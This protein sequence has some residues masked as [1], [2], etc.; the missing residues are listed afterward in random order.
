LRK[1]GKLQ[2]VRIGVKYEKEKIC[3]LLKKVNINPGKSQKFDVPIYGRKNFE[4]IKKL[5]L[6]ELSSQKL[7]KFLSGFKA[8]CNGE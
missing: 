5:R 2:E 3:Q 6:L 4:I 7:N 1:N 8:L